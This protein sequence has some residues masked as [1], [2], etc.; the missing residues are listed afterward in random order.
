VRE[1]LPF[2]DPRLQ[3]LARLTER[4]AGATG[5]GGMARRLQ[6]GIEGL[7]N[8]GDIPLWQVDREAV[9]AALRA[10]SAAA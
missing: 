2:D 3:R 9:L 7:P 4:Y 8:R 6:V 10:A 5:P 1:H